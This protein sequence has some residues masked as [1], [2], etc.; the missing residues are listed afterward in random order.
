MLIIDGKVF[1]MIVDG[2]KVYGYDDYGDCLLK[3]VVKERI[4]KV[5]GY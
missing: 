2:V 5:V 4:I 3:L 1:G